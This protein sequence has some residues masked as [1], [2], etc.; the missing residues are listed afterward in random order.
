MDV[1]S[2]QASLA[3]ADEMFADVPTR[4]G[5]AAAPPIDAGV[6]ALSL[7]ALDAAAMRR[8]ESAQLA[9]ELRSS[10]GSADEP[11]IDFGALPMAVVRPPAA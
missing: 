11:L 5:A 9:A 10:V 6:F 2:S 8:D 1:S 3:L 4:P 7:G